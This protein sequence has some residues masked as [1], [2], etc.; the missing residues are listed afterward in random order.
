MRIEVSRVFMYQEHSGAMK[1]GS[2]READ[3]A[4]DKF[5]AEI[6]HWIDTCKEHAFIMDLHNVAGTLH[7]DVKSAYKAACYILSQNLNMSELPIEDFKDWF[8]E[9][10]G[11]E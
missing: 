2:K 9:F 3:K 10:C 7:F 1:A 11:P 6:S 4:D 8:K 5:L